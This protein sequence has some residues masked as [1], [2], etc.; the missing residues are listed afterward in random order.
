MHVHFGGG[1]ELIDENQALLP[2]YVA[3]GITT[4][5][6]ASGDLPAQVLEWRG[7]IARGTLFGPTLL[8]SGP[9]IEGLKPI[10]KGTSS[11]ETPARFAT[12]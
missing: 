5:R 10:W 6:D 8:S 4:V 9:K 12:S 2:L 3:H 11:Q 1:V 7:E